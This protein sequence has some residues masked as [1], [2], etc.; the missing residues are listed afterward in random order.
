MRIKTELLAGLL[1]FLVLQVIGQ[2]KPWKLIYFV[3]D[4]IENII[5]VLAHRLFLTGWVW[6]KVVGDNF[7]PVQFCLKVVEAVYIGKDQYQRI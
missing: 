4:G 5:A 1:L 6:Q 2:N 3:V 7:F